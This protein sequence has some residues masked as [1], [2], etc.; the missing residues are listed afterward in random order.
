[1][2][3]LSF[4]GTVKHLLLEKQENTGMQKYRR[5]LKIAYESVP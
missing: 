5:K 2:S 3:L 1:M 4:Y